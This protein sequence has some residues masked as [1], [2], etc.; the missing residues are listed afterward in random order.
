MVFDRYFDGSIKCHERERRGGGVKYPHHKLTMQ[1]PLSTRDTII[2]KT[3]NKKELIHQLCVSGTFQN[4]H[5]IRE[6]QCMF[7]HGEADVNII[8]YTHHLVTEENRTKVDICSDDN[9]V[10]VLLLFFL[11]KWQN[12]DLPIRTTKFDGT[13]F[14]I[15]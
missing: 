2:K 13:K 5:L 7:G 10:F 4:V 9:D 11:W 12:H 6:D 14:D 1:T 15:N 8:S 3:S